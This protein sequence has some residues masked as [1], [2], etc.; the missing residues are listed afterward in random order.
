M[1]FTSGISIKKLWSDAPFTTIMALINVLIFLIQVIFEQMKGY[2]YIETLGAI[3]KTLVFEYGEYYRIFTSA[4]LH[5]DILHLLFNVGFGLLI[6][7]SFLE[8]KLGTLRTVIIYFTTLL[9]SGLAVAGL[10]PVNIWTLGASGAIFGVLGAMLWMSFFRR[11]LLTDHDIRSIR[12]L[13]IYNVVITL[14]ISNISNIG[15]FSGLVAGFLVAFLFI[16]RDKAEY[17]IYH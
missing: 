14:L 8:R 1:N 15:H 6:I 12:T 3:Q 5:A 17:E 4:F 13:I 16:P 10:S 11:D 9:L 2:P 7:T